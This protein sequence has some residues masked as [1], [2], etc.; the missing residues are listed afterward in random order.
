MNSGC[1]I[2]SKIE[3]DGRTLL[4]I[5]ESGTTGKPLPNVEKDF[6]VYCGIDALDNPKEPYFVILDEMN[7]SKVE[8]YFSDL[9]S[10]METRTQDNEEGE[11]IDLHS[12]SPVYSVEG[13]EISSKIHIP[14]NVFIA[15]TVNVD[16]TTYM[17]SPKVLDR[18]NVI[19]FNEVDLEGYA[20]LSLKK[21]GRFYLN[22]QDLK[23]E[24]IKTQ[25]QPFCSRD[26][27]LKVREIWEI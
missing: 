18:A 16:E 21:E 11:T 20:G 26:D 6:M 23:N 27:Y 8:M 25:E 5:D 9:L 2:L 22:N 17:F 12:Q 19:E 4:F 1:E 15:G 13:N 7:L 24:L 10:I 3:D 14:R